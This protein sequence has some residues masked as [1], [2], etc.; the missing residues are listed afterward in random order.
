MKKIISAVLVCVL[1]LSCVLTLASCANVLFGKYEH[2]FGSEN[3]GYKVTYEFSATKVVVTRQG[4]S[5]IVDTKP[6]VTEGTY[7]ISENEEGE[8]TITFDFGGKDA[9]DDV[10]EEGVTVGFSQGTKDGKSFIEI[11]GIE[12]VRVDE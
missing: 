4:V 5:A 6:V 2:V 1:L 12:F 7:K 8:K 3:L 10:P 9:G 11:G